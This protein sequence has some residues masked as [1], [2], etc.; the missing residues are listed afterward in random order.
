MTT[1]QRIKK[2]REFR[3][4]TQT[5]FG[6]QLGYPEKSASVRIAQYEGSRMPKKDTLM[7]MSQI[8]KCN[9]YALDTGSDLGSAEAIMQNLFWLEELVSGFSIFKFEE[10]RN[11][12][13]DIEISAKYNSYNY[14]GFYPPVG[15]TI[16]DSLINDFMQEWALRYREYESYEITHEEYFEWKI[17]WPYSCDDCG[18]IEPSY[19][20]R[21]KK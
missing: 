8:L 4:L 1:G 13:D 15:I 9:Y 3:G 11:R 18:K 20:W 16:N 17:N 19:Q 2:I 21:N 12:N 6:V 5:A 14:D 10:Y 7:K